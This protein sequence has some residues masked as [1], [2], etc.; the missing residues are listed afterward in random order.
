MEAVREVTE[1]TGVDYRQP[2]HDYLLD[3]DR[4]VA[5]RPWGTGEIRVLSGKIKI[6]RR[7]RKF[8]KLKDDPFKDLQFKDR[9]PDIREVQGS[10]GQIYKVNIAEKS[11]TCQ[12]F[13]FRGT[14]KHVAEIG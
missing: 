9:D 12:G 10:K 3:G 6:D 8:I 7:G 5:Y 2:N 14:C 1:W 13:T 11:C 4:V